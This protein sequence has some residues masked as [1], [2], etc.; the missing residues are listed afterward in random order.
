MVST[1]C[2]S[3]YA[4]ASSGS[5]GICIASSSSAVSSWNELALSLLCAGMEMGRQVPSSDLTTS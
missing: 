4:L 5:D 1:R 2:L 3:R